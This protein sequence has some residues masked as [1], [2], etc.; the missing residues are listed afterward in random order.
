MWP[1]HFAT[2]IWSRGPASGQMIEA[3][4]KGRMVFGDPFAATGKLYFKVGDAGMGD[5]VSV[6]GGTQELKISVDDWFDP[7][8]HRLYLVQGRIRPSRQKVLYMTENAENGHRRAI[9]PGEELLVDVSRPCFVRLEVYDG[10]D[11]PLLF[12]NPIVFRDGG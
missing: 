8:R 3:I 10:E 12:T 7:A 4:K 2:W 11:R 9:D 1:N 5:R 6:R